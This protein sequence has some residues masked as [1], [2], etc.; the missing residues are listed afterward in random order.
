MIDF[1]HYSKIKYVISKDLAEGK[2]K[3]Y[4][5]QAHSM[6]IKKAIGFQQSAK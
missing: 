4:E 3:Q 1:F 2:R 6:K 5:R